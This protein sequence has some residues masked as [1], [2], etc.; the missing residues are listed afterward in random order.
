EAP[1][2]NLL[3]QLTP[4]VGRGRERAALGALVRHPDVRLVTLTGP[5]GV[6]KTRLALQLAADLLHD[7]GDGAYFVP[8]APIREPHLIPS[9]IA[10]TLG[11]R[12]STAR[13]LLESVKL[14]L[15]SKQLLLV[16][17]N[18]EYIIS[19][20]PAVTELLAA[21]PQL[22]IVVTSREGL[23][24]R[25]EHEYVV[26][27][28]ELPAPQTQAPLGQLS[29]YEAVQLFIE[30]AQAVKPDF[31]VDNA[32]APAVAE[33]CIRLDGLPLAIEL[34]AAR[35]KFFS[36][37]ALSRKLSLSSLEI[38]HGGPRDAP[39]RHR[40]LRRAIAWSYDLLS[41]G[42]QAVFRRLSVFIG[43]F[44]LEA[45]EAVCSLATDSDLEIVNSLFS[46]VN[47]SLVQQ[48][49]QTNGEPRFNL[50]ETV[51][52]FGLERLREAHEVELVERKHAGH[53][54]ALAAA[55]EPG[56]HRRDSIAIR[57]HLEI[58]HGNLRAAL[59]WMIKNRA[60]EDSLCLVGALFR[61]WSDRGYFTEARDSF[62]DVLALTA[63]APPSAVHS[64]ALFAAGFIEHSVSNYHTAQA[65]YEQSLAMGRQLGDKR[66]ISYATAL[67]ANV[68]FDRGDFQTARLY[69]E[70]GLRMGRE[71]AEEW[72]CAVCVTNMANHAL[73]L[74]NFI[75]AESLFEQALTSLQQIG[76]TWALGLGLYHL[77]KMAYY[78]GDHARAR[79]LILESQAAEEAVISLTRTKILS[80]RLRLSTNWG[81]SV[82]WRT[83]SMP[84]PNLLSSR[85]SR[86]AH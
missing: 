29:Q 52:E 4:L 30:R 75:E 76:D 68:L 54:L 58:E 85:E 28:L 55:L 1:P 84:L 34:A 18:F 37:Q 14:H 16:L 26:P 61:F 31:V 72:H 9:A 22:K 83:H 66:R 71:A 60:A 39:D 64:R 46:L 62:R 13:P 50:L 48:V 17:D 77:A 5:G 7:F 80:R 81:I 20:A 56:I 78:Q 23:R 73:L 3:E 42:E 47:K 63:G 8:L 41:T 57:D 43:G 67:L 79:S 69:I 24:V 45:A 21:C 59:R 11:V 32:S 86:C 27:V 33:I 15:R 10:Q 12:E 38:L 2:N 36:P 82:I 74:G 70:E 49:T 53:F 25:G 35:I 44:D 19:A 6:G 40:T 65:F 51:R